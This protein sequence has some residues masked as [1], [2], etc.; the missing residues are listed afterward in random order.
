MTGRW[1]TKTY[2]VIG[3][4]SVT[5][6]GQVAQL[7]GGLDGGGCDHLGRQCAGSTNASI[8]MSRLRSIACADS[9]ASE[10]PYWLLPESISL[11]VSL[12]AHLPE[13][14]LSAHVKS[15]EA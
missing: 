9:S 4:A 15:I 10:V 3:V 2:F 12:T 13:R 7:V 8:H 5:T 11:N 14:P 1:D 6:I